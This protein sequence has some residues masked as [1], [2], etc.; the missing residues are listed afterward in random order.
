M[1]ENKKA[2][3]KHPKLPS[4]KS[5]FQDSWE[6]FKKTFVTYLKIVGVG[7][8]LFVACAV[9]AGLCA[10]PLVIS[11][12]GSMDALFT[13]T[14]I[15]EI[16]E[17]VVFVIWILAAFAVLTVYSLSVPIAYMFVLDDPNKESLKKLFDRSKPFIVPY[18]LAGLLVFLIIIG[19]FT[20]LVVPGIVFAIFFSFVVNV[21]VL[22]KLRGKAALQR[23]YQL[24]KTHFWGVLLRMIVL[25]AAFYV[26][27]YILQQ[28]AKEVSLFRVV[29]SAFSF[30]S[31]WFGAVYSFLLY[32]QLCKSKPSDSPISIRWIWIPAIVGF[33]L[34]LLLAVAGLASVIQNGV[35]LPTSEEFIN[36][37][38]ASVSQ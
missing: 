20:L 3:V 24:V 23:S 6:L 9:V 14:S 30:T 27:S 16:I 10:V 33:V 4:I 17:M 35:H 7:I 25:E 26:I 13:H 8:L 34:F 12:G 11:S 37:I 5:L 21:V 28:I 36:M 38:N 22:E 31:D 32:K 15:L 19:G 1:A 29:S 18:L 2:D